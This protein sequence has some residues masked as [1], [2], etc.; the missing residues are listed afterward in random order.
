MHMKWNHTVTNL[1]FLAMTSTTT[2]LLEVNDLA[3]SILPRNGNR[4]LLLVT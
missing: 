3:Y 4:T 2:D 1:E